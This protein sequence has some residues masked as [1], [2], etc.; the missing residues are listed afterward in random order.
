MGTWIWCYLFI[1][2]LNFIGININ[3]YFIIENYACEENLKQLSLFQNGSKLEANKLTDNWSKSDKP[4][5][6]SWSM[7]GSDVITGKKSHRHTHP[8]TNTCICYAKV[9]M[10]CQLSFQYTLYTDIFIL[11]GG[12]WDVIPTAN[13]KICVSL[14][15]DRV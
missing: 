2:L 8:H 9:L 10:I 12:H 1:L 6:V 5:P 15:F 4:Q 7:Q 3:C 11:K 14:L 13:I